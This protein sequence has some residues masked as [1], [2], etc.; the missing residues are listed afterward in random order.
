MLCWMN[1]LNSLQGQR[2]KATDVSPWY[3]VYPFANHP[4]SDANSYPQFF[5]AGCPRNAK[6]AI[7]RD[8]KTPPGSAIVD[9]G[10]FYEVNFWHLVILDRLLVSAG[11]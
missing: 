10:R 4:S 7:F 6:I 8:N 3:G 9:P 2:P 11:N 1:L 5:L